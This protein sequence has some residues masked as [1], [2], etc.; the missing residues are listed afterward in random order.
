MLTATRT[1]WQ[2]A[3][4]GSLALLLVVAALPAVVASAEGPS[5]ARWS[6]ATHPPGTHT[7]V[8]RVDRI[9]DAIEARDVQR[10]AELT[11]YFDVACVKNWEHQIPSRPRCKRNEPPGTRVEVFW[12][13]QCEGFYIRAENA[14]RSYRGFG[15]VP[16]RLYAVFR[17]EPDAKHSP[18]NPAGGF[19]IVYAATHGDYEVGALLMLGPRGKITFIS[20]GCSATPRQML[21]A[22]AGKL[23]LPPRDQ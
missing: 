19:G 5:S 3:Q 17:V 6:T 10:L 8:A 15:G 1:A 13:A 18:F 14:P 11:R 9:L 7:G 4:T 22:L 21:D 23:L 2:A 12:G 20:Y 16:P